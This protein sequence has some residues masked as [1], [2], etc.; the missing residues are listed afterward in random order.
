M[1][2]GSRTIMRIG[3]STFLS[4]NI[5]NRCCY[6][7]GV[8]FNKKSRRRNG[9]ITKH[10]NNISNFYNNNNDNSCLC[11]ANRIDNKDSDNT[12]TTE[13]NE[14]NSN[15][16]NN[17]NVSDMFLRVGRVIASKATADVERLKNI[18][19]NSNLFLGV[20][21]TRNRNKNAFDEIFGF[22]QVQKGVDSLLLKISKKYY[23]Y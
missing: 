11:R 5:S 8:T 13:I 6:S 10:R 16:N 14:S 19:N 21:K 1:M 18:S 23:F 22:W 4:H 7:N 9:L 12:T 15:S 20:E 17:N 3:Q 2:R